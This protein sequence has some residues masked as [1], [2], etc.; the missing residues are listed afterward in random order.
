MPASIDVIGGDIPQSF[1]ITPVVIVFDEASNRFL[2]LIWHLMRHPVD[3]PFYGAVIPLY[4]A[5]GLRMEG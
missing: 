3:F 5:I 2:Q 1:V 4:L